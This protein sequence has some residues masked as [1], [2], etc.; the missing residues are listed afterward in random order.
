MNSRPLFIVENKSTSLKNSFITASMKSSDSSSNYLPDHPGWIID[1]NDVPEWASKI[2]DDEPS[3]D[4][5]WLDE[6]LDIES[7]SAEPE[8]DANRVA[9]FWEVYEGLLCCFTY[10][11]PVLPNRIRTFNV[12]AGLDL[13]MKFYVQQ[14]M[15][16]KWAPVIVPETIKLEE[17]ETLDLG[18]CEIR[19]SIHVFVKVVDSAGNPLEGIPI[20]NP[21]VE[22]K[23]G[24]STN[25]YGM[26]KFNVYPHSKGEFSVRC[27][28]H[29]VR[30]A[31]PYKIGGEEDA[32]REFT[33]VISD[34]ML[35]HFSK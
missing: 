2:E 27:R 20:D 13:H 23:G 12:P 25:S 16:N 15:K 35:K 6:S 18:R 5:V 14:D 32:G 22:W 8:D 4:I 33:M 17:G 21:I 11:E 26:T 31:I 29:N 30:E 3:E 10:N 7:L 9:T 28:K 24:Q 19:R 1:S 34:K